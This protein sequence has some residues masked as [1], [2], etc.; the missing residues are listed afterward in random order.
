MSAILLQV[1]RAGLE[2]TGKQTVTV[3]YKKEI[4]VDGKKLVSTS[5]GH[6]Q[7]QLNFYGLSEY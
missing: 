6:C 7:L 4:D 2:K 5:L 3:E 1:E